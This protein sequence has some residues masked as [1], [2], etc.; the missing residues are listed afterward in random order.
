[1]DTNDRLSSEKEVSELRRMQFGWSSER[2]T[3]QIEQLEL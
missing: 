1:M 2:I 3:R